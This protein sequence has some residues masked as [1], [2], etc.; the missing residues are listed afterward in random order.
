MAIKAVRLVYLSGSLNCKSNSKEATNFGCGGEGFGTFV[1][2]SNKKVIYPNL[3][4]YKD[5]IYSNYK[6]AGG[7]VKFFSINRLLDGPEA[8]LIGD[9]RNFLKGH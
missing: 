5:R 3:D 8:Y 4:K 2:D 6:K 9:S 7:N 1:T